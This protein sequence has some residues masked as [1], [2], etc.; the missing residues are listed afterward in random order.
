VLRRSP[1][2]A[3]Y[4]G[5]T[6][7]VTKV[8]GI[9]HLRGELFTVSTNTNPVAFTL[10]AGDRPPAKVYVPVGMCNAT[11]GRLDITPSGVATVEAEGENWSNAQ[12]LT[13]LDGVAFAS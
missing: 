10:P 11:N 12:C 3:P 7:A 13:S 8:S 9:V 1:G 6:A 2:P 4:Y 5:L